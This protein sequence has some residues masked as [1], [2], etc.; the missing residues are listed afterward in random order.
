MEEKREEGLS[1]SE[2]EILESLD[3]D[4]VSPDS[5]DKEKEEAAGGSPEAGAPAKEA[6][7]HGAEAA[8][9]ELAEL[10][11]KYLRLYA[12]FENYRKRVARDKEELVKY[13]N[14][15]LIYELLTSLDTLEIAVGHVEA[16]EAQGLLVGVQNTLR[17]LYR[18]LEKFGLRHIE[19]QGK[20]F[21]PEVHHAIGRVEREDMDENVVVEELRK[22][23]LY[24]DKVLRASLVNVSVKPSVEG[25]GGEAREGNGPGVE[26]KA[27]EIQDE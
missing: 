26:E 21:N 11:D 20:P 4:Y 2:E 15:S 23:F 19:A 10:K 8:Q 24:N 18:T 27:E 25:G 13:G 1:E 5:E 7:T 9:G 22:G 14:E 16:G 17:G 12:Q 6:E 3:A